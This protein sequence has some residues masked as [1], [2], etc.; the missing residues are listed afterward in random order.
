MQKPSSGALDVT[1]A[2]MSR[3]R[4]ILKD[5]RFHFL[6]ALSFLI[7]MTTIPLFSVTLSQEEKTII[8]EDLGSRPFSVSSIFGNNAYIATLEFIPILGIPWIAFVMY[9]T[10]TVFL[11]LQTS[12]LV[13]MMSPVAWLE[14]GIYSYVLMKSAYLAKQLYLKNFREAFLNIRDTIFVM[15]LILMF[16]AVMEVIIYA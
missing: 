15:Y 4:I 3:V 13:L 6:V 11:A 5:K 12:P 7:I 14:Y 1:K 8:R 10:G 9:N 2:H 16:G